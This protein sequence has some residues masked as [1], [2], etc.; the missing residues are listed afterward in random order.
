[1]N[2][3]SIWYF[4]ASTGGAPASIWPVIIP[5]SDTR[6]TTVIELII[7]IIPRRTASRRLI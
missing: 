1:M 6:P 7:G 3:I 2:M 4:T 5:G